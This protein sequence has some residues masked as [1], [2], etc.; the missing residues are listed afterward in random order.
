MVVWWIYAY[1]TYDCGKYNI[2]RFII[3]SLFL[4]LYLENKIIVSIQKSKLKTVRFKV[5]LINYT[6]ESKNE[7]V[8]SFLLSRNTWLVERVGKSIKDYLN[9]KQL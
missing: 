5:Y 4:I 1:S 2:Y 6:R 8:N 3:Y 7:W 9:Y